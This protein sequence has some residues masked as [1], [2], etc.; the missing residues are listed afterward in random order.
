[1]GNGGCS[2]AKRMRRRPAMAAV[3]CAAAMCLA[4][5]SGCGSDGSSVESGPPPGPDGALGT[6][7]A[8]GSSKSPSPPA[9]KEAESPNRES[10]SS[11]RAQEGQPS[12]A[13]SQPQRSQ[14]P[15]KAAQRPET[16]EDAMTHSSSEG[17]GKPAKAKPREGTHTEDSPSQSVTA[18]PQGAGS[19]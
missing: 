7:G 4:L 5:L 9:S 17:S 19:H 15:E 10:T 12:G 11:A 16:D 6:G 2:Q 8:E 1:M 14:Q 3:L 13:S 18:V